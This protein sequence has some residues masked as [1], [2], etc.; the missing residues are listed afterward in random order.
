[1]PPSFALSG[2]KGH[3]W[4]W[5]WEQQS[6]FEKTKILVK[7]IKALGISDAELPFELDV[8]ATPEALGWVL[9]QTQQNEK[10]SLGFWPQLWKWAETQYTHP[11]P[12]THSLTH[13]QHTYSATAPDSVYSYPQ[14]RIFHER[15]AYCDKNFPPYQRVEGEYVP[16]TIFCYGSDSHFD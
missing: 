2:K 1:M 9:Q 15:T 16:S 14:G 11:I 7:Q 12:N 8:S 10:V 5:E 3:V 4:D 6:T 13:P